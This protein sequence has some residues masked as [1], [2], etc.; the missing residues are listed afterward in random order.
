MC[1]LLKS[2]RTVY[3]SSCFLT[4][5]FTSDGLFIPDRIAPP[6]ELARATTQAAPAQSGVDLSSNFTGEENSG[7][8]PNGAVV[9][10][11]N[12]EY[13]TD[14][15]TGIR[16]YVPPIFK[17]IPREIK[18]VIRQINNEWEI[19]PVTG[20][21]FYPLPI[22]GTF[23]GEEDPI[24]AEGLN[25]PLTGYSAPAQNPGAQIF[26]TLPNY[27]PGEGKFEELPYY[28]KKPKLEY[29]RCAEDGDTPSN[30]GAASADSYFTSRKNNANIA[31]RLKSP[32]M[33]ATA[34]VQYTTDQP[35]TADS[36]TTGEEFPAAGARAYSG[37]KELLDNYVKSLYYGNINNSQKQASPDA[38]EKSIDKYW[39]EVG[40][41]GGAA[42]DSAGKTGTY[43]YIND[44]MNWENELYGNITAR[45]DSLSPYL[46]EKNRVQSIDAII[47][48]EAEKLQ[49]KYS[50]AYA[51]SSIPTAWLLSPGLHDKLTP[52]FT[53]YPTEHTEVKHPLLKVASDGL[54]KG[55]L[56]GLLY[57]A[58]KGIS[59]ESMGEAIT[60]SEWVNGKADNEFESFN[61]DFTGTEDAGDKIIRSM[62]DIN[63]GQ[64]S[65]DK[66]F[67]KHSADFGAYSDGSNTSKGLFKSDINNLLKTGLQKS[68]AYR[69]TPG[70]HVFNPSTRQ[71][72]F[73][74][75]N[76]NFVTAF[77]LGPDQ[78]KYLIETGVVK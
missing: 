77:K 5:T 8:G 14:L 17:I 75:A 53:E 16:F 26:T 50:T 33:P 76:G 73:Y 45:I 3:P 11:V 9:Q 49:D 18:T 41:S 48:D 7:Y 58:S 44:P 29:L 67:S 31:E 72:A 4:A 74:D 2:K 20:K 12:P 42:C 51:A 64:S 60:E 39:Y 52:L 10:R 66:A 19:D 28:G 24:T 43:K 23:T 65:L 13:E 61:A 59:H 54:S 71:W 22:F 30:G 32:F 35:Q 36:I 34:A 15:A 63:Y 37:P 25:T 1:N 70:T 46:S 38:L 56:A 69:A 57:E 21:I 62:D 47:L 78:F 27:H 55:F 68:G 6:S 40:E